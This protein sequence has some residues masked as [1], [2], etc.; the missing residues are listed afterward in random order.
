MSKILGEI[1]KKKKLGKVFSNK[2]KRSADYG[3]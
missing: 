1:F 3:F 2:N